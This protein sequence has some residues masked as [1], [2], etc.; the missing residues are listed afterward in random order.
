MAMETKSAERKTSFRDSLYGIGVD[1]REDDLEELLDWHPSGGSIGP[2][3]MEGRVEKILAYV[4][5][6][7]V[8][9]GYRYHASMSIPTST[10]SFSLSSHIILASLSLY[11]PL[12]L[13]PS[14]LTISMAEGHFSRQQRHPAPDAGHPGGKGG[15]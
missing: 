14:P 11:L 8:W 4:E 10:Y 1:D 7:Q 13:S 2:K 6:M 5:Q 9:I 15:F 12:P 3:D